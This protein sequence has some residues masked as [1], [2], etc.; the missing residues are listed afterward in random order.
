M[1]TFRPV[2]RPA[3]FNGAP[4]RI[5]PIEGLTSST[6]RPFFNRAVGRQFDVHAAEGE[7]TEIDL[8]DEIGFWGVTASEFRAQIK[9]KGDLRVRINSPGG[10]VFDGIA[11]HN[12]LVDHPGHVE[13]VIAGLAASAASIVAM[14]GDAVRIADNAFLMIHNAWTIWLGDAAAAEHIAGVLRQ[15]DGAL[16]TTYR[17]RTGLSAKE[18][19]EMMDAETWLG[20]EDAVAKGFADS[21]FDAVDGAQARFDLTG[22][23]NVPAAVPQAQASAKPVTRRDLERVLTQDAGFTRSQARSFLDRGYKA[24]PMQDAGADAEFV[25]LMQPYLSTLPSASERIR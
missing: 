1:T 24:E 3:I 14:A 22:F 15:I 7:I 11:M 8:Y 4:A 16:N 13:V 23:R 9:G 25:R 12:D 18:I 19:T 6:S 21:T 2:I 17:N 5:A 10:D 20:A